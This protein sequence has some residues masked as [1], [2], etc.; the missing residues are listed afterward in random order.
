MVARESAVAFA[1]VTELE[2]AADTASF[3]NS[4]QKGT[5]NKKE[6]GMMTKSGPV[7]ALLRIA[8]GA[9]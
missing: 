6:D 1:V 3:C 9:L 7:T 4:A 5:T 8:A 2:M